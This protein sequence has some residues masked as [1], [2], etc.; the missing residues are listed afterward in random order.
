MTRREAVQARLD[1]LVAGFARY[2]DSY[3]RLTPFTTQQAV[4]HRTTIAKLESA[5]GVAAAVA[6]RE[7]VLS[8]HKTLLT[9]GLGKRGSYL[10]PEDEFFRA[11]QAAKPALEELEPLHISDTAASSDVADRIWQVLDSLGVVT[12]KAR[13]VAGTKTLHH[14]LPN[15]VVPMDRLWTGRFFGLHPYEWQ[16]DQQ[17][18]FRRVHTAFATVAQAVTPE[19][20]V[21][22]AGWSTSPAKVLDNALI[23]YGRIELSRGQIAGQTAHCVS[24]K[25]DGLPPAKSE[26]LS[27]LGP[28]HPHA[29]RVQAL[30]HAAREAIAQQSFTP[31]ITEP[32]TLELTVQVAVGDRIPDATNMLGGVADVLE[33]KASRGELPHLGDLRSVWLYGNDRQIKQVTY[34]EISGPKTFYTVTIQATQ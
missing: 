21:T 12:N 28:Q 29:P 7:F 2:V 8:L 27:I 6:D 11:L 4:A 16:S 30:L 20:Y 5:G 10:V 13:L 34:R 19:S 15:L 31:A 32:V 18:T 3:D 23:A 33:N 24:F 9:W 22:G 14:L 25:V 1:G 17:R 26:A